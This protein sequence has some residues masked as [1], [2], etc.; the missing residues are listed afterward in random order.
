MEKNQLKRKVQYSGEYKYVNIKELPNGDLEVTGTLELLE[1]E[2]TDMHEI[3]ED[4]LANT[5]LIW[6]DPEDVGVLS[7]APILGNVELD[8]KGYLTGIYG[9]WWYPRYQIDD[10]VEELLDGNVIIFEKDTSISEEKAVEVENTEKK[11]DAVKIDKPI[12][13]EGDVSV[14]DISSML[15]FDGYAI[16][17][18]FLDVLEDANFHKLRAVLVDVINKHEGWDLN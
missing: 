17:Q 16:S 11:V 8:D 9:L 14:S 13:E 1:S 2:E 5:G 12:L 18:F 10:M 4:V 7:E 6:V 15:R 3:F